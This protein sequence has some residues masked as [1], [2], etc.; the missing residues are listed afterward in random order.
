MNTLQR[1]GQ[2]YLT[3]LNQSNLETSINFNQGSQLCCGAEKTVKLISS[4]EINPYA[5]DAKSFFKS[6]EHKGRQKD[7]SEKFL[8]PLPLFSFCS[9]SR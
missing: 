3:K 5:Y 4:C 9:S 6:F 2:Q 1:C 7:V 8:N